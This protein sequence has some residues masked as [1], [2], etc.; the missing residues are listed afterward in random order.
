MVVTDAL[1][2]V[3]ITET[4]D[5]CSINKDV[6]EYKI[7]AIQSLPVSI[8]KLEGIWAEQRNDEIIALVKSALV[9]G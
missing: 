9:N 8:I 5:I 1:S 2:R 7:Q 4:V 6:T 3:V